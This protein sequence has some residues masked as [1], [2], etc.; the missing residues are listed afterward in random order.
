MMDGCVIMQYNT[1]WYDDNAILYCE[2]N[3]IAMNGCFLLVIDVLFAVVV[4]VVCC[5]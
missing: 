5:D 1:I 2:V 4:V 3:A